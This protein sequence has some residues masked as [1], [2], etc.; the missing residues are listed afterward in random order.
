[1]SDYSKEEI[2]F[3][4]LALDKI[5]TDEVVFSDVYVEEIDEWAIVAALIAL[6]QIRDSAAAH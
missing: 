1:M 5:E 4:I 3:I 2:E 6:K